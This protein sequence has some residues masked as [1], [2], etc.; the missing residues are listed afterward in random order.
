M[1]EISVNSTP[2][3]N[4]ELARALV[5]EVTS[6]LGNAPRRTLAELMLVTEI[7]SVLAFFATN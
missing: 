3:T 5:T 2:H 6:V 1:T 7:Q 4:P